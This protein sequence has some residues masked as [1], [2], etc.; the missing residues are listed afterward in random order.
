MDT[1]EAGAAET[2]PVRPKELERAGWIIATLVAG[3][4]AYAAVPLLGS[5]WEP[6]GGI[7]LW[8]GTPLVVLTGIFRVARTWDLTPWRTVG[9]AV[10][11][12]LF[13]GFWG[14]GLLGLS[15]GTTFLFW[16][17]LG[18]LP[19]LAVAYV[20]RHGSA[21]AVFTCWLY[22]LLA[23]AAMGTAAVVHKEPNFILEGLMVVLVWPSM[24]LAL[25]GL[26]CALPLLEVC[27]D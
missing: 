21:V 17:L 27:V 13:V 8:F 6:A 20:L 22:I 9:V 7:L 19:L 16:V 12:Y 3:Y 25:S 14:T 5:L 2:V 18:G 1:E 10:W 11:V 24:L 26:G 23:I 15:D 4:L